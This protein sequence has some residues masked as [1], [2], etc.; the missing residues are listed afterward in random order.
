MQNRTTTCRHLMAII[1]WILKTIAI[2]HMIS[3]PLQNS[4]S[5][6]SIILRLKFSQKSNEKEFY[7]RRRKNNWRYVLHGSDWMQCGQSA[8]PRSDHFKDNQLWGMWLSAQIEI[9]SFVMLTFFHRM[10]CG[11]KIK[12]SFE[13]ETKQKTSSSLFILIIP[14]WDLAYIFV[15]C[16]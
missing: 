3:S 4:E 11:A 10:K 6:T 16:Y 12:E 7:C 1:W 9:S 2:D 8:G 13:F 14:Y 5:T 15:P